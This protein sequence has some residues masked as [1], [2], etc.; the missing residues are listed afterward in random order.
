MP[1]RVFIGRTGFLID[2]LPTFSLSLN[3]A[4]LEFYSTI[5]AKCR[6]RLFARVFILVVPTYFC[7]SV[8]CNPNLACLL[9]LPHGQL[10]LR[11]SGSGQNPACWSFLT[12]CMI[13]FLVFVFFVITDVPAYGRSVTTSRFG[14]LI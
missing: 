10:S 2:L 14:I 7:V 9:T 6:T 13:Y 1:I 8:F 4:I 3:S 11:T 5:H 12:F